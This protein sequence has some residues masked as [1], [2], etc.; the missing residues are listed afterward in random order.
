[1]TVR[2]WV[3]KHGFP[4]HPGRSGGRHG[5]QPFS[6]VHLIPVPAPAVQSLTLTPRGWLRQLAWEVAAWLA[7]GGSVELARELRPRERAGERLDQG[8]GLR[9]APLRSSRLPTRR[10]YLGDTLRLRHTAR[11]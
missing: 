10:S 2:D 3:R 6:T 1:M 4:L 11:G 8:P 7:R 9:R 5:T